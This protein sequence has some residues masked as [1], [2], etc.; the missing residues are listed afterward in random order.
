LIVQ[1]TT[2]T[3]QHIPAIQA[4]YAHYVENSSSTF[5]E[6]APSLLEIQK[7]VEDSLNAD[8]PFLVAVDKGEV[9]G[10]AYA[11]KYRARS[12]YRFT[13]EES[14]YVK[15]GCQGKGIGQKLLNAICD[16]AGKLGYKQ[17]LAVI[18]NGSDEQQENASVILHKK[19]GFEKAG[20]LQ[21]V[22]YKF[23]RWHDTIIM[24]KGL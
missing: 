6:T 23:E 3:S 24:Q 21:K 16:E 13:L 22:G 15:D 8:L 7:R 18:T 2:A 17:M 20:V 4:I 9:V 11:F 12:A 19:C 1:L 5:E 10:Y 14:V